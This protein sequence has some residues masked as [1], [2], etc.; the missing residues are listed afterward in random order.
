MTKKIKPKRWKPKKPTP[1]ER[2]FADGAVSMKW[3]IICEL[4]LFL[5]KV[6]GVRHESLAKVI[7]GDAAHDRT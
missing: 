5:S 4:N 7:R 3:E 6:S 2:G 1:Y